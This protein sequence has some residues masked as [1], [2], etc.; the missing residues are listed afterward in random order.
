[1]EAF[2]RIRWW[3]IPIGIVG[4]AFVG[5]WILVFSGQKTWFSEHPPLQ[6][7]SDMDDQFRVDPLEASRFFADRSSFR[8]PP[9]HTVPRDARSYPLGQADVTKA[10]ELFPQAPFPV[11]DYVLAY[12][13]NRYDIFCSPCHGV[14]GK[15][16]GPVVQRGFVAP[17]DLTRPQAQAYSDAR[18]FHVI[19]AGQNIMP[20]Y[21]SKLAEPERWAIVYY[22]RQLQRTASG[23]SAAQLSVPAPQHQ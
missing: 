1:M 10:E 14:D 3:Y 18:I 12:G 11:N 17:P 16:N 23:A 22:I 20:S 15:G 19:S 9:E 8:I 4:I 21:A 6:I 5:F 7:I 2:R 13:R